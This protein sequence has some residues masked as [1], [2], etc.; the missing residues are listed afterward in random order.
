MATLTAIELKIAT[1]L[2]ES[3]GYVL[4]FT[5]S[6]FEAFFRSEVGVN[7]YDDTY[8]THGQSKGKRLRAFFEKA[9][10]AAVAKAMAALWA[11]RQTMFRL[12]GDAD[13]RAGLAGELSRTIVR[14]GGK[15]IAHAGTPPST[16]EDKEP[17]AARIAELRAQFAEIMT[18]G[19]QPRG[20]AFE[21]FLKQMFDVWGLEAREAFRTIGEQIDGSFQLGTATVLL[22][23][24]WQN[25]L[26]DLLPLQGFQGRL[27][28][29]PIWT[30]GLFVS[31]SG[32]SAAAAAGFRARRLVLMDGF[33]IHEVLAKGLSL[34][35]VILAKTRR[36]SETGEAFVRVRDLSL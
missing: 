29:R 26:I 24:K 17:S 15:P 1:E 16:P 19:P 9:S 5:N 6:T 18:L 12:S 25:E 2:F 14:L 36:A 34:R 28:D 31:Y 27:E 32:Y 21:R 22:E 30:Q 7:I 11:Y 8:A 4:D 20:Y 35:R 3:G 13:T 23:A 33:D 10:D